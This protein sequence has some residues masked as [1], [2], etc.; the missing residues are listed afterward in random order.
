M[1]KNLATTYTFNQTGAI[2]TLLAAATWGLT[3]IGVGI[4]SGR[5]TE[6]ALTVLGIMVIIA[7]ILVPLYIKL[8]KPAF[9]VGIILIITSLI[10][11]TASPGTPAW[12]TFYSPVYN[13]SFVV[14]YLIQLSGIYFSYKSYQEL[15]K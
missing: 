9:I 5:Q 10:G 7:W 12:Y 4:L 6:S 13:F 14:F 11:L 2:A 8:V 3:G 1:V 15:K